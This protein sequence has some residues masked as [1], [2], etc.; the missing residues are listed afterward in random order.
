M[1]LENIKI[2]KLSAEKLIYLNK[3]KSIFFKK[4]RNLFELTFIILLFIEY[5][6]SSFSTISV[7]V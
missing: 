5:P 3:D 6:S 1:L 2:R 4:I 7:I